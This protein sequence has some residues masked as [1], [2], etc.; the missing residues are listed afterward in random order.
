MAVFVQMPKQGN[1]VEECLLVEW[2]VREGDSVKTGDIL[3]AIET[4]KASFE[5]ESTASGTVLKLL[6][7]AGELVPV[8]ANIVAI[9]A[10]GEAVDAATAAAP[11]PAAPAASVAA[12]PAPAPVSPPAAPVLTPRVASPAVTPAQST[13][14]AVSPRARQLAAANAIDPGSLSGSG[15]NGRVT[16]Q[17]VQASIDSGASPRLTPLAKAVKAETGLVAGSGSGLGGLVRA[18]DLVSG[19]VLRERPVLTDLPP[20]NI[21]YKGV[22]KLIGDRMAQSL[23]EHAQLTLNSSADATALLAIRKAV[24]ENAETYGLPKISMNDLVCWVVAQTLPFFPEVN[25]IFDRA[26]ATVTRYHGVQLGVAIDTPRGLMVPVVPD[27]HRLSPAALANI[28]A[29]YVVDCR[30]GSI[31]PDLLQGGTFTVT[32]LGALGV[33]T[34]T[35]VLNTPQVA[36]LGVC[37]ITDQPARGTGGEIVLQPRMGLSLTIDHQV[38]DGAPGARF[39]QAVVKGIE[40]INLSLALL[41]AL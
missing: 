32:N 30:K 25:A 9:G 13:A 29:Q 39:L 21:P 41:G 18:R 14:A 24:K 27:A 11:A 28:V 22:R 17:D 15:I 33:E 26:G 35:P 40:N 37:A 4:D 16:S 38:V 20:E 10:A 12:A 2:R 23:R 5:V 36:I 3:C 7:T 1:T 6:A 31:L 8:L 34:F 19:A